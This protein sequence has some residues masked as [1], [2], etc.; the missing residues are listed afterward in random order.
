MTGKH[1]FYDKYGSYSS[2][3]EAKHACTRDSNCGFVY[4]NS[5]DESQNDIYL[6]P[7]GINLDS[8]SSSCIYQEGKIFSIKDLDLNSLSVV[9]KEQLLE[10]LS[11]IENLEINH[12]TKVC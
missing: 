6:C 1:C 2:L 11:H 9:K 8:S 12:K 5:C 3:V 10:I 7:K 4:D